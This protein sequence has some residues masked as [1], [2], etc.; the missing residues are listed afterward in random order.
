MMTLTGLARSNNKENKTR[1]ILVII[2]CMLSTLLLTVIATYGYGLIRLEKVNAGAAYGTFYGVL[3]NVSNE[4]FVE[5]E[6]RSEFAEL[7]K[8]VSAGLIDSD[9]ENLSLAVMDETCMRLTNMDKSLVEGRYPEK[10]TEIAAQPGFFKSLGLEHVQVGDTVTFSWRLDLNSYYEPLTMTVSGIMEEKESETVV[11]GYSGFVSRAFYENCVPEAGRRYQVYFRLG[12]SV[13]IDSDIAEEVLTELAADCGIEKQRLVVNNAYLNWALDPGTETIAGCTVIAIAVILFS[14]IVIYNIFQVGI[15]QKIQEYGKLKALGATKKQIRKVVFGEGMFLAA[16]GIPAGLVL[17]YLTA[18]ISFA[19]LLEGAGEASGYRMERVSVFSLPLLLFVA[20]VSF[21][22]VWV[23]LK[24]PMKITAEVSPIEAIRYQESTGGKT[25]RKRK[26]SGM[27]K[28]KKE[29]SVVSM[30][31]ANLAANKKRMV[32]TI[33]TMGLSCVL[34]VV[35]ANFVGNMDEE[36][37]ARRTVEYGQ[38]KI[39]LDYALRDR[40]YPENNL[41]SVLRHNPLSAEVIEQIKGIDGVSEVKT[42]KILAAT[43]HGELTSIGVLDRDEFE[44]KKENGEGL[45]IVDYDK[46]S[47]E[48]RILYGWSHFF[49][50][51]GYELNMPLSW[52]LDDG[53]SKVAFDTQVI[54]SF[55]YSDQSWLITED[56]YEALGLSEA[57]VGCVWVDCSQE[58]KEEVEAALSSLFEGEPHVV[59][60]S[61]ETALRTSVTS[62]RMMKLLTYSLLLVIGMI[63]FMNMANTMIIS[64]ITRK[65][66]FGILQAVG[67][68]NKQ[69]NQSLQ[70]EGV[71]LTVGIMAVSMLVGIPAG[72]AFFRYGK[73]ESF[74]GLHIYHFP[75]KEVLLMLAVIGMLQ[76]VLSYILSRNV[77]KESLIERIRYQG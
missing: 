62:M 2:S 67:M 54:G 21:L 7:G 42:R 63:G 68:T 57:A 39:E 44:K 9:K 26:E 48:N 58:R 25:G 36:Y 56:T 60:N 50:E 74:I 41:D 51:D 8:F 77:K 38:F 55:A 10:E 20:V 70:L 47:K 69:L 43:L 59:V 64:I 30:T 3:R 17:G 32:T 40:A 11:T 28:G 34:F 13:P 16:I 6:R 33:L 19:V 65:Q 1:S 35:M 49:T 15:I 52:T 23:A 66:E 12:E 4:E 31:M 22:T 76:F 46:A 73:A 24:K 18:A 75:V 37:D 61:Y 29:V 5:L 71:I 27:R 45:G 72:Y 53:E 14:I